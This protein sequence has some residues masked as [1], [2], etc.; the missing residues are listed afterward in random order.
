MHPNKA[1]AW[2]DNAA[3][4]AFI[5]ETVVAHIFTVTPDGPMVAHAP[6]IVA[7]EG[8]L[9]FHLARPNRL[10][11]HLDGATVL[12]SFMGANAY[13]SAD[14][15]AATDQVPTWLYR[16]VEVDGVARQMD[17]DGLIEQVDAL[18]AQ[19]ETRLLPKKPWT[20]AKMPPGKFEKMLPFI[21]GFDVTVTAMRGTLKLNQHK[22]AADI[23]AMNA[24]LTSAC[25]EDIVGLIA[26]L[27][28]R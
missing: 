13:Q 9:R 24:G 14:W 8:R 27:R 4:Y 5:T 7:A 23:A 6:V 26:S 18:S 12:L 1:F 19:M 11:P 22:S 10:V 15:Y 20:R 25:R 21:T 17:Q 28:S 16:A 3:L 2:D